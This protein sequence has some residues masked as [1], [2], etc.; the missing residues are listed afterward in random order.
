MTMRRNRESCI[1]LSLKTCSCLSYYNF[2][3]FVAS[4]AFTFGLK[5]SLHVTF[6]N[7]FVQ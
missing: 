6:R 4:W 2:S 5:K 1:S 3:L 7:P